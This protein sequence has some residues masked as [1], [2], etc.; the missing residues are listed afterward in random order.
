MGY[1]TLAQL[2]QRVGAEEL[3]KLASPDGG[4]ILSVDK[5]EEVLADTEVQAR[6]QQAIEDGA[7]EING[8]LLGHLDMSDS[9]NIAAEERDNYVLAMH[10]LYAKPWN[11]TR[12]NPFEGYRAQVI[13]RL[14]AIM[15][16]KQHV[17]VGP[18]QPSSQRVSSKQGTSRTIGGDSAVGMS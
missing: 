14:T 18:E 8:Y 9:A 13:E 3:A 11:S 6:V 4:T 12:D 15:R 1:T 5:A 2:K 17:S 7:A 16:G 10:A